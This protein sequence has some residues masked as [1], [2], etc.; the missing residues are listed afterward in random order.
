MKPEIK[1]TRENILNLVSE[2]N[3]RVIGR[4]DVVEALIIG[5]IAHE[6]VVIV[7][8]PGCAKT[9][10]IDQICLL[11]NLT[12]FKYLMSK[13]TT[14]VELFGPFNI[15]RLTKE[16]V[17]ERNWSKMI[18]ADLIFLDEIF[19]ASSDV[20]N[21]LLSL[22]NE[23]RVYDAFTGTEV[24]VRAI[25]VIGA[26][27]EIPSEE[28]LQAL[29]DRF[30]IR[31]FIDYLNNEEALYNAFLARWFGNHNTEKTVLATREDFEVLH[32]Y[33]MKIIRSKFDNCSFKDLFKD[34]VIPIV[35]TLRTNGITI[36]DRTLI[37]KLPKLISAYLAL[38]GAKFENFVIA[39]FR[40]L[41]YTAQNKEQIMDIINVL[42]REFK[43]VM[44]AIEI[45]NDVQKLID[46]EEYEKAKDKLEELRKYISEKPRSSLEN[47]LHVAIEKWYE[48]LKNQLQ[49]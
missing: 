4:E 3:T 49:V 40:A 31:L 12:N 22:L 27:N 39:L 7:S 11:T 15:P 16:G 20:L 21:M 17:L 24:K 6:N 19:K 2:L 1:K 9:Y 14:D 29:Y 47:K 35:L 13:M 8:P 33:A 18:S 38:Y 26:S 36:S 28:E 42:A 37:E 32:N 41:L 10:L 23:R 43:T 44:P 5:M 45:V 48:K 30:S 34:I 46:N 25:S